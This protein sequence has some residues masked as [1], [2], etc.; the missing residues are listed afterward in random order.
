M[1]FPFSCPHNGGG[2]EAYPRASSP[3]SSDDC[4]D[5]V[6]DMLKAISW[7]LQYGGNNKVWD[8]AEL[9]VDRDGYLNHITQKVPETLQVFANVKTLSADVIRNN[10]ITPVGTHGV[11]QV[12]DNSITVETNECAASRI[13]YW[14]FG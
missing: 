7:N 10:V 1:V 14:C 6:K 12:F 9:Y 8:A 3:G 2:V 11:T 4:C 13:C 5:D